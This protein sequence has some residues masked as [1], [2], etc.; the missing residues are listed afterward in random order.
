LQPAQIDAIIVMDSDGE[1]RP[2]DIGI[3]LVAARYR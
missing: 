2:A 3:L 1:D